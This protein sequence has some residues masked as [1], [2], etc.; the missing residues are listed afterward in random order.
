MARSPDG[1]TLKLLI[2]LHHRFDL[3]TAPPWFAEK[4][5]AD[6]P[7]IDVVQLPN[8]ERLEKEIPGAEI[9]M[10]WSLRPQ[11]FLA[12]RKLRWIHSPAAAVHQLMFPE[13][14]NSD[15]VLTNAS[16]V[17]G[18][19]VAEHVIAL[20]FAL[21]K[22]IPQAVRLQ[23]QHVWGQQQ[24]WEKAPRPRELAEA[25]LGLVGLGSIGREVAKR[26][27]TLGMRVIAVREH[28]DKAET[29]VALVYPPAQLDEMLSQS[30]FVV[31]AVPVTPRTH[32][33][34]SAERFR[35]MKPGSY[36]INVGRGPLVDEAALIAALRQNKIAG[37]A[38]DVFS[39]E[40][41]SSDSVLWDLENLLITPH[42]AGLTDKL[43]GRHYMLFSENLRRYLRREPL[44]GVVDKQRGY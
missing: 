9:C 20:I 41:L 1:R 29:G 26:A 31:L 43:W 16:E 38:L 6:F 34:V 17:H 12:A 33:L 37:A 11:Q 13:L 35:R 10:A 39:Q 44:L 15:V 3:W 30:D 19:V 8:Y 28:A 27:S 14:V 5:R 18:P 21:A 2:V 23:Q 42:T 40:P 32:G 7:E 25:T 24:L 36:L 4:L 22:K